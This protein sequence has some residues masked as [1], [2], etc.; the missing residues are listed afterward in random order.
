MGACGAARVRRSDRRRAESGIGTDPGQ[1]R[2]AGSGFGLVLR[3]RMAALPTERSDLSV[4]LGGN[5]AAYGTKRPA[6][7]RRAARP[8]ATLHGAKRTSETHRGTEASG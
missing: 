4:R 7:M 1:D 6:L 8:Q 2:H 5:L 3:P